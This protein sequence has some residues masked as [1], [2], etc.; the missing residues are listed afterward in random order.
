LFAGVS[1]F[2]GVGLVTSIVQTRVAEKMEPAERAVTHANVLTEQLSSSLTDAKKDATNLIASLKE[3][4]QKLKETESNETRLEKQL[5]TLQSAAEL[6]GSQ[7]NEQ[8]KAL[9][10]VITQFDIGQGSKAQAVAKLD[11]A[12]VAIRI[13]PDAPADLVAQLPTK[14]ASSGKYSVTIEKSRVFVGSSSLRFFYKG[15]D[16][17]AKEIARVTTEA[18][19]QFG[20]DNKTIP[21]VDLTGLPIKP[22]ERTFE[23]WLNVSNGR[24]L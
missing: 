6:A 13:A 23:I 20:L 16:E 21:I 12:H 24:L 9:S 19:Q 10:Q 18:L 7:V 1:W 14:I 8:L 2:G 3:T 22:P 15:D 5:A 17:S 11:T 4:N